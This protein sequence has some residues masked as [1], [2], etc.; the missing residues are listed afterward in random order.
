VPQD[1]FHPDWCVATSVVDQAQDLGIGI[2]PVRDANEAMSV[3]NASPDT[4]P[5]MAEVI[6]PTD[7]PLGPQ[8]LG[9]R[10]NVKVWAV[11]S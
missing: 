9:F 11:P 8:L 4:R 1:R 6:E 2:G 10:H 7:E 5:I 3:T